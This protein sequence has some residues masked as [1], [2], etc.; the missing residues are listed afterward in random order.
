MASSIHERV[1]IRAYADLLGRY[2]RPYAPRVAL[3]A[4]F[5][6][7][8][9][10]LRLAYP[11]VVRFFIDTAR[12]G[13]AHEDLMW[14]AG[15]Y[16]AIGL[17]RQVVFLTGSYL[18][19]DLGWRVTN[20][21]RGDLADHCLRLDMGF[22][23][24][25]TP[26]ELVERVDGDTTTL[27]NFFSQFSAQVVGSF[28]LLLG[29]LTLVWRE[30]WRIGAALGVFA[31]VSF[32]VINLT[33]SLAVPYYAAERE[34]FSKLFG[35][36]EE[37]LAGIEDVRTNGAVGFI[38]D[39]FFRVNRDAF[40][41]VVRSE[42]MGAALRA[43]IGILFAG[44]H[45]LAMSMGIWL[46][47]DG[48]FTIGTVYLIFE[49]TSMLRFPLYQIS[50]QIND[51]QRATAGL[52]RIEAL[53]RIRPRITDGNGETPSGP[54]S[55]EF[56]DVSFDYFPGSPVLRGV[57]LR[58]EAGRTLGLLG[59]TGGGKTTLTRLLF[60]FYDVDTGQIS[61]GD[62]PLHEL[63]LRSL[64]QRV[65]MVTQDVQI[66]RATVRENLALFDE[67]TDDDVM[68]AALDSL[69]MT[70]WLDS[71]ADGLDTP[72]APGGLSAGE[73]QL[74]A[75]ARVFLS[76]PGVVVLDEPSSR[77]DPA[78]ERQIDHAVRELLRGRTA[79]VIAH[80]LDTVRRV[81][82]IAI[83]DGGRILETGS[84]ETL[85]SDSASR[86]SQLLTAGLEEY[87]A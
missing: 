60:R 38:L 2:L 14:A 53:H 59:R 21:M 75:F 62:R 24:E 49:Y 7:S 70:A 11:Q 26:G 25:R 84:R 81:D 45:A 73:S 43:V 39:R 20:T 57:N 18:G 79:I 29:V 72:I 35:F 74:L 8:G 78:T 5:I 13:G 6:F 69:G 42:T 76:D 1:S 15:I 41:R 61:L 30:D 87:T 48:V 16:L 82:D 34:G 4:L 65:G 3:L 19:Q 71:L 31:L 37:R 17:G 40:G 27:S 63:S 22:H 28:F 85:A 36:L 51:L 12:E 44:G 50:E 64:R 10:G 58:L 33:R 55:V 67:E 86:F 47:Q 9:I 66:F 52:K 77:L 32:A 83:L 23:N 68:L 80:H 56:D 54:L 46:Y